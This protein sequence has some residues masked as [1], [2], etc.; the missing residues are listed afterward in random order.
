MVSLYVV[1]CTSYAVQAFGMHI[2]YMYDLA[3]RYQ[4]ML[5]SK[6]NLI[7]LFIL[8]CPSIPWIMSK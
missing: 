8:V 3:H 4:R 5:N 1:Q 7:C 2:H 6:R